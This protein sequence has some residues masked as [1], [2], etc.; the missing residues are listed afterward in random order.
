MRPSILTG[1]STISDDFVPTSCKTK[2]TAAI[3]QQQKSLALSY[4]RSRK[5]LEDLLTQRIGS[6]EIL[7]STLLRVEA[8][9]EEIHVRDHSPTCRPF[10]LLIAFV[11]LD[12]EDVREQHGH[13]PHAPRPPFT[14]A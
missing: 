13:S 1:R 5:Q 2:A 10:V 3:R 9:A 14:P 11:L 8:A 4:L 6:L 12:R 7:Q